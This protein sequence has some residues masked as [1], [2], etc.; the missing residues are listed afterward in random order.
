MTEY[1][2]LDAAGTYY[3]L[4]VGSISAYFTVFVAYMVTAYVV[5]AKLSRSQVVIINSL[6]L[7][8]EFFAIWSVVGFFVRARLL[9][10]MV[11]KPWVPFKPHQIAL[12]LLT[13]GVLAC[14]KFMWDVRHPKSD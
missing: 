9:H 1:E 5:G 3:G 11:Y 4:G 10:E 2:L 12:P 7:M 8:M 6:F 13:F 14:L